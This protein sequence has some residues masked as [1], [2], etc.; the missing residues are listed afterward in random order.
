MERCKKEIKSQQHKTQRWYNCLIFM[1]PP[2][3]I[4]SKK[5]I[6]S[7]CCTWGLRP[8]CLP[9]SLPIPVSHFQYGRGDISQHGTSLFS[10][11]S[12]HVLGILSISPT[13]L[14]HDLSG[15]P[16]PPYA[17][18]M[19]LKSQLLLAHRLGR[20]GYKGTSVSRWYV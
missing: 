18:L 19:V 1:P 11:R 20:D 3:P 9:C 6:T 15:P 7:S 4:A 5:Y 17:A 13:I 8:S 12:L 16:S 14:S 10:S 2:P